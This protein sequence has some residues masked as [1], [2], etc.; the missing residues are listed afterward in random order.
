MLLTLRYIKALQLFAFAVAKFSDGYFWRF[1]W[2]FYW[3]L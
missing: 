1:M 2:W 3:H